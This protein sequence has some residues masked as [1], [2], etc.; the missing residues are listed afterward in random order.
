MGGE[1]FF[2]SVRAE[3]VEAFVCSGVGGVSRSGAGG[4]PAATHFSLLRQRKVSKRK[5]PLL[6]ASLRCAAGNLRCSVQAGSRSTR[7]AQTIAIPDPPGPVLLGADRR[8]LRETAQIPKPENHKDTPW[9]VLVCLGIFFVYSVL[10]SAPH[11]CGW[12][13]Q[14]RWRRDQGRSCLS[15]ASSADPR[16]SR[17]AQV[18][19]SAA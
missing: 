11:P 15:E 5:A 6:S 1:L 10:P 7:C 17:A 8:G 18:A 4:S 19:R 13:E 9:R 2:S 14:R 16:R 12:A 3:P